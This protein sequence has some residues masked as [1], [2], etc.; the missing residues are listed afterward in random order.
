MNKIVAIILAL[1]VVALIP[2]KPAMQAQNASSAGNAA[3]G[4][5]TFMKAGC[6][7]C[8][9][10][11]GQ[12]GEGPRLAPHMLP[13]PTF[14]NIVRNGKIEEGLSRY[15]DGMPA[16]STRLISDS[17]L[18]DIYS[19]LASIPTPAPVKDMQLLNN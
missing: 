2:Q 7:S 15:W 1:V 3:N 17:E 14:T 12:G 19:Y 11:V 8:H 18:A 16:F 6:Y 9:G 5:I 10:S 13:R 4:K